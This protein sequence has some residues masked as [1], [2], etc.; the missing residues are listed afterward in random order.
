MFQFIEFLKKR[1]SDNVIRIWRIIFWLIILILLWV[2][3]NDYK[4]NLPTSAENYELYFKYWIFIFGIMPILAWIFNFCCAKMKYVR[5]LQIVVWILLIIIWNIIEVKT[6]QKIEPIQTNS[7]ST[8][9]EE[10]TKNAQTKKPIDVGF[11]IALLWIFPI[12]VWISWKWITSK[13]LKYGETITK[14]RV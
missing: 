10:L 14:I 5:I 6:V 8:S 2:Y 13:C 4:I 3:F 9:F 12:L 11:W 1:P 7:W